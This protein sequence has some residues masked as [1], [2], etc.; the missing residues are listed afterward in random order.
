MTDGTTSQGG[1]ET[2]EAGVLARARLSRQTVEAWPERLLAAGCRVVAPVGTAGEVELAEYR[3]PGDAGA[4][5]LAIGL[6]LPKQSAKTAYFP[7]SEAVLCMSRHGRDWSLADPDLKFPSTVLFGLRPCDAAAPDILAPLFGWDI[8]D[9]FFEERMKRITQIVVSCNAPIDKACFCTS[10]GVDP[11]GEGMGDVLLTALPD[12]SFLAEAHTDAGCRALE[13]LP[14]ETRGSGD[15]AVTAAAETRETARAAMPARFDPAAVR[16]AL[17]RRFDDPI[18]EK[19]SRACIGCG[20]CAF[21]CPTCHCFDIQEESCSS[22]VVRQKNWDACAFPLFTAHTSG[23][24]PRNEQGG[25]WRQRLSHKFRYYPEKFGRILCTG[26]GRCLRLCPG[27]MDILADLIELGGTATAPAKLP[28]G[29]VCAAKPGPD[30][31]VV[32]GNIYKPYRMKIAAMKDE[33]PDVRTLRLEFADP[34]E[35]GAFSFKVGQFGLYSAFGAGEATFC[36]ASSPTRKGYIEC[37]FRK[38]GRVTKALRQLE[39]G[40]TMGFR[41]PYGNTFPVESWEG[42]NILFVAGG[43]ALPPMRCVI[44]YCLDRR[45]C[46]RDITIVYGARTSADHVY[47][48]ELAEWEQR[49]DVRLWRCI[50]W[51]AKAGGGLSD[52]AA[53]EG[54]RPIDRNNPAATALD[55]AH[56]RYTAFVPQLVEAAAP[57]PKDCIAVVCGPPIM[58]KFTLQ[59]LKKLGF[60]SDQVFTTLENRMKCGVGKCGRCNVGPIYV[61]K[62]GPVFTASQVEQLPSIEL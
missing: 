40:D 36:V 17:A 61:C 46:Y 26:C 7:R 30:E 44:Q 58:I 52:D 11:A 8:H 15:D 16:D 32:C 2:A 49:P 28:A 42:R 9:P 21:V 24:N 62:E 4:R 3:K 34:A 5:P 54:W 60:T 45:D 29:H 41:G 27:G 55:P 51:K 20:T 50:D 38:A 35:A 59:S 19:I 47:K 39:V 37:T 6:G 1:T 53:E 25:R 13:Q 23:H 33:T 31:Q 12:G 14:A 18:W 48:D 57:S 56:R 43:I 10:V 22:G